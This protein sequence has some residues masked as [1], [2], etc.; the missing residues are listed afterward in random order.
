MS[1][2]ESNGP[3]DISA[4]PICISDYPSIPVNSDR[5]L[6]DDDL[7]AAVG[8]EDRWQVIRIRDVPPDVQVV[9]LSQNHQTCDT[10]LAVWRSEQWPK[11]PAVAS[12][13]PV[14]TVTLPLEDRISNIPPGVGAAD[15]TPVVRAADVPPVG[16]IETVQPVMPPDSV[17]M[18]P[19]SP[20]P[21]LL[22][23]WWYHQ[24]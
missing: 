4:A 6:P 22:R 16:R 17:P 5:V 21:A 9:G 24:H 23:I 14:R 8:A 19:D 12:Q 18:S 3:G 11:S 15:L 20:R 7:L 1:S 10:R 13:L 2:A